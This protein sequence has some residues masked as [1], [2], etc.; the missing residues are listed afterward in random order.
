MKMLALA[1]SITAQAFQDKTDRGGKPYILHCLKV[2]NGVRHL[3]EDAMCAAVMH[4]L[5]EDTDYTL[6]DIIN[7]KFNQNVCHALACLTHDK[8]VDYMDYIREISN[9]PLATAIKKK[10]LEHNSQ[11]TRLKDLTKKDF[12]RFQKYATAY[13]YLSKI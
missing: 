10:D 12:D 7:L 1:I 8:G 2:M 3:G 5:I 11:V 13:K 9:D 4:D 6:T